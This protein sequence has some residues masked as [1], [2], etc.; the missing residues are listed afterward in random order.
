VTGEYSRT[1][2]GLLQWAMKNRD[3]STLLLA[4]KAIGILCRDE[5]NRVKIG[6][7]QGVETLA[8][9]LQGTHVEDPAVTELALWA[10]VHLSRPVGGREGQSYN[11][12]EHV[13]YATNINRMWDTDCLEKCLRICETH[14]DEPT[15]LAKVFWLVVNLSLPEER[16]ERVLAAPIVR[17][18]VE[19]LERFPDHWELCYRAIFSIV[20]VCYYTPIKAE[21]TRREGFKHMSALMARW[22]RN[23][24]LQNTALNVVKGFTTMEADE[25]LTQEGRD[26][27]R[28]MY[29]AMRQSG[30]LDRIEASMRLFATA[31]ESDYRGAR[32]AAILARWMFELVSFNA[33]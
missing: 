24:T 29:T 4:T 33:R 27:R 28:A 18:A 2:L 7:C 25:E 23:Y 21:F 13:D 14:S 1:A 22:P 19:A 12:E 30:L 31:R 10:L 8:E 5:R 6:N 9:L 15:V 16:T 3:R 20:N 26:T 17:H 32:K 11:V